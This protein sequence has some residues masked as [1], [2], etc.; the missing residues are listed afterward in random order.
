MKVD[1]DDS[2][3][4]VGARVVENTESHQ[5]IE[6]FM[7]AANE[8]VARM[9]FEQGAALP[10]PHPPV[11][12]RGEDPA[13]WRSS[14]ANSAFP[15]RTSKAASSCRSCWPPS[16]GRPEQRAVHFAV[17]RSL[18][19]A[20]YGP[21]KRAITPWPAI[22][23]AT[24]PRPIRRYPDLTVHRL[25]GEMLAGRKPRTHL[26]DLVVLGQHCSDREQRAEAAERDLLKLKL[27]AYLSGRIGEEMDGVVTGV[28]SFGLFVEGLELPAQGLIH[29]D[30]LSDDYYDFDRA[31]H[32][33]TGRRGA[34]PIA[35]ATWCAWRSPGSIWSGGSWTSASSRGSPPRAR[36]KKR[37]ARDAGKRCGAAVS[38]FSAQSRE[39]GG[40]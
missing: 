38:G 32:S 37:K 9:L 3:R 35:S 40:D 1:L 22:A 23:T 26:D 19:R 34:R 21:R 6:E 39:L 15:P 30:A 17:L 25:L 24:S 16:P 33:L 5:I 4:V 27:L 7:L 18:Q 12:E 31:T 8:A 14:S 28:E 2:G 10:P 20:V 36:A 29:A 11:A 13:P